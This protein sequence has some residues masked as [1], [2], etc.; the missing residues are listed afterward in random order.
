[1]G[2]A[3]YKGPIASAGNLR[4]MGMIVVTGGAGFIG[5]NLL[6]ALDKRG[7]NDLVV[8]DHLGSGDK[9]RNIAKRELADIV[10]P[11]Q[12]D[13]FLAANRAHIE[14]IFHL[15][16]ISSTT[17]TD[18]DLIAEEN[19]RFSL[20]LWTWTSEHQKR[21]IYAS[22]AATYGDGSAGFD[23]DASPAGLAKL[24]PLNPYGWSKHVF[25]RRVARL[26]RNGAAHPSQHVGL[27][28]FNVYGPNEYHKGGQRS[29]V[30]QLYPGAKTGKAAKLFKS[31][32]RNYKDGGQLRDFIWVGDCVSVMLW[33]LDHPDVN[34]LFN[35]GTGKA[36]SFADLARA[37][38]AA[39]GR[40]ARIEY[41]P[42]PIA[43]RDKYQY[44]TEAKMERLRA[45]GYTLPMTSLEDG[46]KQYV[47]NYL[48]TDDPYV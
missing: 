20:R 4:R 42:T 12:L 32:N 24:R 2:Y 39:A 40:K 38:Y 15:G 18:V 8:V 41:V 10:A 27:K 26:L 9:W 29:V 30:H 33:L 34:G 47:R 19:F 44:F 6:A 5:S 28:F 36:R 1:M 37:L 7:G 3:A 43:I 21:L 23:D 22:S 45:A 17:E 11:D 16:A 25:D 13:G 14:T 46:I 31:H 48:A 35:L